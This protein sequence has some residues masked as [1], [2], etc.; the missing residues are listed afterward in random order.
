MGIRLNTNTTALVAYRNIGRASGKL[1]TSVERLSSGLR[2]NHA[3]DDPAGL[4]IA[5]R[6]RAQRTGM[7]RASMN[8]QDGVSLLQ[9]A[10]S[11]LGEITAMLTRIRELAVQAANGTL[12]SSDRVE[13]QREVD[14]LLDEVDRTA[15]STEFNT[16]KLL[17]GSSS[18]LVSVSSTNLTAIVTG[19]RVAEGNYRLEMDMD[20]GK[21]EVMKSDIFQIVAGEQYADGTRGLAQDIRS[22]EDVAVFQRDDG[23]GNT[24]IIL[25]RRDGSEAAITTTGDASG[26]QLSP[27]G[28]Q[29]LYS[30][31]VGGIT[32]LYVYDLMTSTES[33][34]TNWTGAG[35]TAT[36]AQWSS[37]GQQIAYIGTTG[38]NAN[39]YTMA[40]DATAPYNGVQVTSDNDVVA[41]S[42]QWSPVAKKLVYQSTANGIFAVDADGTD[43]TAL[44]G[45]G[46]S[47]P[48]WS[49]DGTSLLLEDGTDVFLYD[50]ASSA[51]TNLT[52]N[53]GANVATAAA[54]SADG[55]QVAYVLDDGTG[56]DIWVMNANGT[57]AR[58][59]TGAGVYLTATLPTNL[60]WTAD[61]SSI[62]FEGNDGAENEIYRI[63]TTGNSVEEN[64]TANAVAEEQQLS[65][66][67]SGYWVSK[68]NTP[69]SADFTLWQDVDWSNN[70]DN[71]TYPGSPNTVQ[72]FRVQHQEAART[73]QS[74]LVAA[75]AGTF[76]GAG[77][78]TSVVIAL[79]A[80]GNEIGRSAQLQSAVAA[81]TDEVS[82]S[83]DAVPNAVTY[84]V[85]SGDSDGTLTGYV[86]IAS[87]ATS[88]TLTG[89]PAPAATPYPAKQVAEDRFGV[90][91]YDMTSH[92]AGFEIA[93]T[94]T[95]NNTTTTAGAP[96]VV[97]EVVGVRVTDSAASASID[98]DQM[99]I[100]NSLMDAGTGEFTQRIQVR[101]TTYTREGEV[102]QQK[103]FE[104]DANQWTQAQDILDG[105]GFADLDGDYTGTTVQFGANGDVVTVH[106]QVVLLY[107]SAAQY[108]NGA[109]WTSQN[110][111]DTGSFQL[112]TTGY[113]V[114]AGVACDRIGART[115]APSDLGALARVTYN[116]SLAWID[117]DGIIHVA[118]GDVR[119][120][121]T[122]TQ[123]VD[124]NLFESTLAERVTSLQSIDRF[125]EGNASIFD[126]NAQT[127]TM[128]VNGQSVD[129]VLQASDT[130]EEVAG[131]LRSAMTASVAAGG[132]GLGVDG[133]TSA[134]GVDGNAAVFVSTSSVATD[135]AVAGT[136]ILR[137]TLPGTEGRIFFS[138]NDTL[139]NGFSW[140]EVV[141]PTINNL[142]VTVYDA[143]DGR[144]IGTQRVTD[145]T[146]RSVIEGVDVR[147]RQNADVRVEWN[148]ARKRY[149][150]SSGFGKAV[151]YLHVVD[152]S[153]SL[154][155]GANPGQQIEAAIGEVT[156]SS[157]G[158]D[159][160]LLV[161]PQVAQESLTQI[162]YAVD[163]VN[164][165][166][167]RMGAYIN[168]LNTTISI[169]DITQE[170]LTASESRIRDVD[171]ASE[172]A[173]FTRDQ[174]LVQAAT[175]MLAQ[176][177][178]LPQSVLKLLQ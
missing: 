99:V 66:G 83:W 103:D 20:P 101:V 131:K 49:A 146:L 15:D 75:G 36:S 167:A 16:K 60:Q 4:A 164:S 125:Q 45:T 112:D 91:D 89:P 29:V 80:G 165:Q 40:T 153:L 134:S 79:D 37:D 105:S 85:W 59:L 34:V 24:D 93:R 17:D 46:Y 129:I 163:Y 86:D 161:D 41:G 70:P 113:T 8:A 116:Q 176:A 168:R 117:D 9:T 152:N 2:I 39:V 133:D 128:Y 61:G 78:V 31:A 51:L 141:S 73:Q 158:L 148:E 10:E 35:D 48:Q 107:D 84:R 173:N 57:G 38:G 118:T 72:D 138:G 124:C 130:I 68:L 56:L 174:I 77:L 5:E 159:T 44:V 143:H 140:A 108:T 82:L 3:Q 102:Q 13:I 171:M 110:T 6:I 54:W 22:V 74:A 160:V 92:W 30:R 50:A 23:G 142:S 64:V 1:G 137:S 81:A 42:V 120:S 119:Y 135:E 28:E 136:I 127:L 63:S 43:R 62:F 155:I 27:N 67:Q 104:M 18:A 162:D 7:A 14:Q 32:N 151:E 33:I 178:T 65:L 156:R 145:S 147:I 11:A 100:D 71:D 166:R 144:L 90:I 98:G 175:A 25:R 172:T 111:T 126:V 53:T 47:R 114:G 52:N 122:P 115:Q 149:E 177:N 76:A 55:T 12:T 121:A 95:L 109:V 69:T 169:L 58:D 139:I 21:A 123:A 87:P 19:D 154:Q 94:G 97:L 170:N 132:L 157:L 26:A 96:Y 150:F 106:D 88:T